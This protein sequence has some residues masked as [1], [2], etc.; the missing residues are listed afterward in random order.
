MT[1]MDQH[2]QP[3][4][5]IA[6]RTRPSHFALLAHPV[7]LAV[8]AVAGVMFLT[9]LFS[10][11]GATGNGRTSAILLMLFVIA[12]LAVFLARQ[13]RFLVYL[14]TAHY[15]V[16]NY[17]VLG[18]WGL[19]RKTTL[20]VQLRGVT[21]ATI[22]QGIIERALRFGDLV[23]STKAGSERLVALQDPRSFHGAIVRQME[24]SRHLRGSAAY[25]LH[26]V[27]PPTSPAPPRPTTGRPMPPGTPAQWAT[28][29]FNPRQLRYWDGDRWTDHTAEA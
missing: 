9:A 18:T 15:V 6:S 2:L 23:L 10:L 24:D 27:T 1:Q 26:L 11:P 8:L 16:T 3:G 4:E 28:D 12:G 21:G 19:L 5:V 14:A 22:D 20:E 13:A 7:M 25:P 17:R 29:P